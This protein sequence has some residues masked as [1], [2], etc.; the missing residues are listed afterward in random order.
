MRP[1]LF[2]AFV[3]MPL[4]ELAVVIQVG[5]RIGVGTTVLALLL[6]SIA[7]A[8]LVKREGLRAW[9]R[10]RDALAEARLPAQE[11]TDG[12]LVLFAGA[13]LLTPGFVTDAIGFLL[14]LPPSRAV[15]NRA[16]RGKVRTAIGLGA[17][18]PPGAGGGTGGPFGGPFRD[19][20]GDRGAGD[21]L[22]L[23]VEVVDVR[24]S[25]DAEDTGRRRGD[26]LGS[27]G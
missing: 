2:L 6:I 25:G 5:Q 7:G 4:I 12:A 10:F 21:D 23:D 9:T 8:V 22:D 15:V 18:R 24:R 27:G 11:V 19:E 1:L 13:L 20:T 14:L 26:E 17:V 3:V 16:L